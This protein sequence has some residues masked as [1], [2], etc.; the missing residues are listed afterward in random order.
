MGLTRSNTGEETLTFDQASKLL[1]YDPSTGDIRWIV[2]RGQ[3]VKAGER[4]G[5]VHP[6]GYI[7]IDIKGRGYQ[8]HR[9]AFLLM[10]GDWPEDIIDHADGNRSN[11]S[12]PNLSS[13]TDSSNM[14]NQKRRKGCPMVN[15]VCF[16]AKS[17]LWAAHIRA[18]G[19]RV[20]KY[21]KC[22]LSA[23]ACRYR[24]EKEF[25]FTESHGRRT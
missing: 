15:G 1:K 20:T 2:N 7:Q 24:L 6:T 11:N 21:F 22:L 16:H 3:R 12:W 18:D 19:K 14:K 5:C 23:I 8:A 4:A 17:G 25:G 10:T 9:V 13:A